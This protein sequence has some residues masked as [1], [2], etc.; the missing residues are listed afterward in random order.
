VVEF[1]HI[2]IKNFLSFG[3]NPVTLDYQ[4]GVD[5]VVSSNG[6]GKSTIG[7]EALYFAV[8]GRPYRKIKIGS[9]LNNINEKDLLVE[10]EFSINNKTYL[11]RR[12]LKPAVF[13]I[14][15]N[16]VL[17]DL[18]SQSKDTQEYLTQKI[19]GGIT[20]NVFR[21]LVVLG[22]NI[23]SSKQFLDLNKNEKDEVF[24]IIADIEI[25]K[26]L[27]VKI[28][29]KNLVQKTII[30]NAEYKI[31]T[32][33]VALNDDIALYGRLQTESKDRKILELQ[34]IQEQTK[35]LTHK[36]EEIK[37][38][39]LQFEGVHE[40][41]EKLRRI[42]TKT[43]TDLEALKH[44]LF[45]N[46]TKLKMIST[47]KNMFLSC[48][49]CE[50]LAQVCSS[51]CNISEEESVIS[52]ITALEEEIKA[53]QKILEHSKELITDFEK[54]IN[55]LLQLENKIKLFQDAA[56]KLEI[57]QTSL[58]ITDIEEVSQTVLAESIASKTE[59]KEN[60]IQDL[61]QAKK[62]KDKLMRIEH[63]LESDKLKGII[64]SMQL[65]LFNKLVNEY[66]EK[67][68]GI[69]Y[70]IFIDK[71]F[72]ERII[73]RGEEK[74]YNSMSNGEKM[75][76]NFSILFAFHKII[77]M[78]NGFSTNVLVL[79]EVLDSSADFTGRAELVSVLKNEFSKQKD[80]IIIS[81]NTDIVSND[82]DFN[83][84]IQIDKSSSFSTLIISQG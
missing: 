54:K 26:Q 78:R 44:N 5:L 68:S 65:P 77:E 40:K 35:T 9:L 1:K 8:F 79:D 29:E 50:K 49:G 66:L 70:S 80:V 33:S 38:Q 72:S 13:E 12:G 16:S 82:S 34:E 76:I 63:L 2:K 11:I 81:H 37:K 43:S 41:Y 48:A 74:E 7:V 18:H 62:T 10:V 46:N 59:E 47:T 15:E 27:K 83:R 3:N 19:M 42:K 67:F 73:L 22:A 36:I 39:T 71:D 60:A 75:R 24:Q 32:L 21:Q 53:K 31:S 6:S 25:F 58:E 56:T 84:V 45:E 17:L 69:A 20:E 28:K 61:T 51:M 64:I 14:Y 30:T 57:K 23:S 55:D 52:N 4:N